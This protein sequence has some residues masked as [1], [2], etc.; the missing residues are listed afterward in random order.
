MWCMNQGCSYIQKG[1]SNNSTTPRTTYVCERERV[2]NG[3][4]RVL[5]VV[6]VPSEGV[7]VIS[8]A[9]RV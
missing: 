9:V 4:V 1:I 6:R 2:L 8:E 3:C 7:R 5:S